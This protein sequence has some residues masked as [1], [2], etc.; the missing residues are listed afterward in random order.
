MT[1]TTTP[2]SGTQVRHP[3]DPL[4]A[5][6]FGTTAAIL[7]RDRGVTD[8]WRIA[9]I[10]LNE[11]PKEIV[12]AYRAGD[13]ITREAI[14]VCWN[15][16]SGDVYK[17]LVS[18]TDDRAVSW[19]HLP[20]VQPNATVDEWHECSEQLGKDPRVI[21]ALARR[22]ITDMSMVHIDMWT[23]GDAVIP[24]RHRGRRIGWCDVWR[25]TAAGRNVYANHVSGL[26][27][28]VDLN[29]MQLL[30]VEDTGAVE[31]PPVMGEYVT[32]HVPEL[33]QRHD[34]KPLE[35]SQPE[36]VSFTLD[37]YELRWQRWRMRIG[38]NYR[39]GVVLHCVGYEEQ[40]RVRSIAHRMSL[41]EMVV[42]YRDPTVDH[43]RR[44]A[45]DVGEWGLGFMTT[46]LTLGCDCL[47]EIRYLDAVLHDSRG[48]AFTI[49]NAMC[50][51]EEDNAVLWKHVDPP[52]AEV[53]R[54]RRLW[55]PRTSPSRTTNT[56]STGVSTR[57]A[58]SSARCAPPG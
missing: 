19:L 39:E 43:Y 4:S 23:Y 1:S 2:H 42:P 46:S 17:A 13:P 53:R 45:F 7:R 41:A 31:P 21:E 34:L 27:F 44:T 49:E 57:T 51:H 35:I 9:S 58:T 14:V 6:E 52:S 28:V 50:I 22:G 33:E 26:H 25:R 40:G 12:A 20:G 55:S 47:G 54:A 37:G 24:E 8:R 15:R 36:G 38:F 56:S 10:E 29:T 11:P 18:L 32:E 3:L 16:D 5:D 30:E 48:V